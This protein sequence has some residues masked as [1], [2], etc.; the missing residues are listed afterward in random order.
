MKQN[1]FFKFSVIDL[2]IV[3]IACSGGTDEG[4]TEKDSRIKYACFNA[5]KDTFFCMIPNIQPFEYFDSIKIFQKF[6]NV[7]YKDKFYI[8]WYLSNIWRN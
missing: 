3:L 1:K 5:K 2:S 7:W 8:L 4:C 6:T